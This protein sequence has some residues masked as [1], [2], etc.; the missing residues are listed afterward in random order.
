MAELSK[1]YKKVISEI[2]EN[3]K[4]PTEREFVK[5]KVSELAVMFMETI[6]RIVETT[7]KQAKIERKINNLQSSLRRI[8]EDIYIMEDE[9]DEECSEECGCHHC[10]DEMH[11]NDYEFEILCPYCN[12]EFVTGKDTNLENEIECPNCHN[13]IELDWQEYCDGECNECENHCYN[14]EYAEELGVQEEEDNNYKPTSGKIQDEKDEKS[15]NKN[16]NE[17]DM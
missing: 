7:E 15:E 2:E 16:E 5:S 10:G 17:D 6:E 1:N 14:E 13:V 11:D 4:D 12:Y 3:I 9:E 8:E